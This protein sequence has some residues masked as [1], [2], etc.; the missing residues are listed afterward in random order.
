M[1]CCALILA[2]CLKEQ[3]VLTGTDHIPRTHAEPCI[4]QSSPSTIQY[5][6]NATLYETVDKYQ[7]TWFLFPANNFFFRR[8]ISQKNLQQRIS[9]PTNHLSSLK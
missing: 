3:Q 2:V 8:D 5:W 4:V 6:P 1:P 9:L 7:G